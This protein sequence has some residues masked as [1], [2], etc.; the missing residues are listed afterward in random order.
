MEDKRSASASCRPQDVQKKRLPIGVEDFADFRKMNYYYVDKT[1]FIK[2]LL[3]NPGKVNLFTRPRRFGKSLN[4]SMLK[5]FLE[6]G[7]DRSLFDGLAIARETALCEAYM[8]QFPVISVSLKTAHADGFEEAKNQLCSIIGEEALRFYFLTESENLNENE[9]ELYRQLIRVDT[10][11]Q[12]I[13]SI[14]DAAL[15]GSL[16]TLSMLLQKHYGRN[17]IILIDEYDVPLAKANERGYYDKMVGLIRNMFDSALKTNG[18]LQ[19]AVL[20]GCLRVSKESIF[21]GLNNLKMYTLL[22]AECD[23]YFGFTDA[24]VCQM[25]DYYG[26]SEYY[27]ITKEWYDGYR[28]VNAY[29]YNPWDVINWCNQ[30]QTN[31]SQRPKSYWKNSS[32][33][34]EVRRFLRRMGNGVTKTQIE[35]LIAG[36]TVQKKIEEQLTYNTMYDTVENMWSLLYATGYLTQGALP[37]DNLVQLKIP[38]NEVREIFSD[39]VLELFSEKVAEDGT[40]VTEFCSALKSGDPADVERVFTKCMGKT[41]SI[42]DTVPS[43]AKRIG[44]DG[45]TCRR[46]ERGGATRAVK[47]EFKENFYHGMIL[48]ILFYKGDWGVVSNR[49]AGDG[50]FDIAIE[51]EDEGIGIIIE[52]KYA[53]GGDLAGACQEALSQINENNYT[54]ELK[55]DDMGTILKYGIACYKKQCR[56]V[57]ERE[58]Q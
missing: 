15:T 11:N 18:N 7:T 41:I 43:C 33:N 44:M 29:V 58:M 27:D 17:V 3:D 42:R 13:Y 2:E 9:K 21:T 19:M 16:R 6:T 35:R 45:T 50:Y 52:M 28:I 47:K 40:L 34:E 53:E 39:L 32:S 23:D 38:N 46:A 51:I 31:P 10:G 54:A 12:G 14:S 8:G 30:L 36:E 49:E 20:T 1:G 56:V 25:L 5:Y 37:A 26:L 22:D 4:M 24:E 48:G 55:E 57:L